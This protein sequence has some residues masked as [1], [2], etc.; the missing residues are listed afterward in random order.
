MQPQVITNLHKRVSMLQMSSF[1][2]FVP[3]VAR[4]LFDSL[5]QDAQAAS[6]LRR[7][8]PPLREPFTFQN[9]LHFIQKP[10]TAEQ[11]LVF[12]RGHGRVCIKPLLDILSVLALGIFFSLGKGL[13][14]LVRM[15]KLKMK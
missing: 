7:P 3:L 14:H 12:A 2:E 1:D 11:Y 10:G 5:E 13:Q 8:W 15:Q 6:S 9:G 4:Y